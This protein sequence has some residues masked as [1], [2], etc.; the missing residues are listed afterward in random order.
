[1]RSPAPDALLARAAMWQDLSR[2]ERAE[3]GRYL[4]RLG[5]TY[6]EIRSLIPVPKATLSGWCSEVELSQAQVEAIKARTGS[7]AGVPRDTQWRR[8]VEIEAIRDAAAAE[9]PR[10]IEEPL[11]V[12]GTTL[13]WAEGSKTTRRLA[14]TNS[15]PGALRVFRKWTE[16]YLDAQAEFVLALHLHDGNDEI[17]AKQYWER[18]LGL[19]DIPFH[20]TFV[21]PPG[22][23]HRKNRLAQGV[24]RIAVRRSTD[25]FVRTM[26]WIDALESALP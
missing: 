9:V 23:G 7:P 26:A 24:C 19:P 14:L 22:T 2:W 15:D 25:H 3:L 8:R 6:S 20:K 13:Y 5:W 18:V 10:L 1:M 12:A 17:A 21:K 11:W 4:R 16:R